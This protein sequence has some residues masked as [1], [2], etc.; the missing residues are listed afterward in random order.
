MSSLLG[1]FAGSGN[2]GGTRTNQN[3]Q[4]Q[5]SFM[6]TGTNTPTEPGYAT[7]FRKQT[8]GNLNN[9]ISSA[10]APVYGDAQKASYLNSLNDLATSSMNSL[11]Q[12]LSRSGALTSGRL[13]QG[14]TDIDMNRNSQAAGFFS[15]IP[16]LNQQAKM[17]ALNPLLSTEAGLAGHAPVGNI[18][19]ST[20]TGENNTE[21]QNQMT[22]QGAPFLSN[23]AANMAKNMAGGGSPLGGGPSGSGGGPQFDSN[24]NPTGADTAKVSLQDMQNLQ[25]GP[26]PGTVT[27]SD[28]QMLKDNGNGT[29]TMSDGSII[30]AS[31]QTVGSTTNQGELPPSSGD[32]STADPGLF[33]QGMTGTPPSTAGPGYNDGSTGNPNDFNNEGSPGGFDPTSQNS[34]QKWNR[35]NLGQWGAA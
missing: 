14:M 7:D 9:A 18:Q 32:T 21:M 34:W 33:G 11:K 10:Q 8:M 22:K 24:G 16:F 12:N 3:T 2:Q 29:Y 4:N 19:T 1:A 35:G 28:G 25:A 5:T 15:Q 17:A 26:S 30:N 20:G 31:G 13:S 27:T 23:L 6:N